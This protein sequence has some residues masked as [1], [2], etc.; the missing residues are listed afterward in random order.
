MF[1]SWTLSCIILLL[2][3]V[4]FQP[5]LVVSSRH[6]YLAFSLSVA[7]AWTCAPATDRNLEKLTHTPR[8]WLKKTE[9]VQ[10][11]LQ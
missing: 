9:R 1:F 4:F 8:E 2:S 3:A 10:D 7:L 6:V 11:T 5:E